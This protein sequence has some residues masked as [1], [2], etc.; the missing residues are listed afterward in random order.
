MVEGRTPFTMERRIVIQG[1]HLKRPWV[2]DTSVIDGVDV[3]T[4]SCTDYSLASALGKTRANPLSSVCV[5]SHLAYQRDRMVDRII[6]QSQH[7]QDPM[8]DAGAPLAQVE[9]KGR[10][11]A[12]GAANVPTFV[13]IDVPGFCCPAGERVP[14]CSIRIVTTPKRR[15]N[16]SM[17]LSAANLDWL[18]KASE[19]EWDIG[20][21]SSGYVRRVAIDADLPELAH[22]LKY[23]KLEG[24]KIHIWTHWR[25]SDGSWRE[26]RQ[27]VPNCPVECDSKVLEALIRRA[28]EDV[29]SFLR[30][31]H[32]PE[33]SDE[34]PHVAS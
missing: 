24:G 5:F 31:N 6:A 33:G 32:H 27:S 21:R 28:E 10:L 11:A 14:E 20:A 2:P 12:F 4:L 16:V 17:E 13:T 25:S 7:D 8:A 15:A 34:E 23:R 3:L 26:H 1:G 30:D 29:L 9:S 19:V 18:L 22:G